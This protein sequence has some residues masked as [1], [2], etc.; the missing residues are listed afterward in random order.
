MELPLS[1][2]DE[3]TTCKYTC[4]DTYTIESNQQFFL[5]VCCYLPT[6]ARPLPQ[7]QKKL[8]S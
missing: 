3:R 6:S 7:I 5:T 2:Y 8:R 4:L 1:H